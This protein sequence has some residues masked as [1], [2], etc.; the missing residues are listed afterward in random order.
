MDRACDRPLL[1]TL[2]VH[3]WVSESL[4]KIYSTFDTMTFELQVPL[5]PALYLHPSLSEIL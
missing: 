2:L 3:K 1:L 5:G 4:K